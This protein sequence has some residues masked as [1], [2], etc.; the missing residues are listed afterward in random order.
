MPLGRMEDFRPGKVTAVTMRYEVKS[1][2]HKSQEVKPV[3]IAR[4]PDVNNVVV[5]NTTCTHLGCSVPWDEEKNQFVC[6]CHGSTFSLNGEVLTAPAPRPLDIYSVRIEN[7]VVM[8]DI[9]S[10]QKRDRFEPDQATRI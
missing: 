9:S 10:V 5:F 6:P 8:V 2:F 4:W 1:G 7:G 3:M